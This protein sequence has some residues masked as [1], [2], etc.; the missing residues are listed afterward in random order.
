MVDSTGKLKILH[1]SNVKYT[2]PADLAISTLLDYQAFG[3]QSKLR[4]DLHYISDLKWEST[5]RINNN[6]P[7]V[8][9][10]LDSS[11]CVKH[12]YIINPITYFT[13]V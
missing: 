5:V 13:S 3:R 4:L 1:I 8:N 6:F 9:Y 12:S 10:K 2:L 7:A 11:M